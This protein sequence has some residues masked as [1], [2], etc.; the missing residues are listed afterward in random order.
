MKTKNYA[1]TML[2]VIAAIVCIAVVFALQVPNIGDYDLDGDYDFVMTEIV[3]NWDNETFYEMNTYYNISPRYAL[4]GFF[5]DVNNDN[6]LD[7][8][9]IYPNVSNKLLM[10]NSTATSRYE[11]FK[12]ITAAAGVGGSSDDPV[13]ANTADFDLDGNADLFAV[14]HLYL[15]Y[16]NGSFVDVTNESNLAEL[17]RLSRVIVW[18]FNEDNLTDIFG[19]H[20]NG[21][22][23]FLMLNMGDNDG[24]GI[25]EFYDA[26][27]LSRLSELTKSELMQSRANS[28][29]SGWIWNHTY[30]D[31]N[32][33]YLVTGVYL[34]R[35]GTDIFLDTYFSSKFTGSYTFTEIPEFRWLNISELF[36]GNTTELISGNST[37]AIFTDLDNNT[38]EDLV[39]TGSI[40]SCLADGTVNS[41]N[42]DYICHLW[43]D[44]DW[45]N[46]GEPSPT[47]NPLLFISNIR[48][49]RGQLTIFKFKN[50]GVGKAPLFGYNVPGRITEG[51]G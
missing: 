4:Y 11:I 20:E 35:N 29:A 16:G 40:T 13:G 42:L 39:I 49:T 22:E 15:G 28:I 45:N 43:L 51:G 3:Q 47:N 25:P 38:V 46:N 14:N 34:P 5:I 24:D 17:P 18:D 41:I 50:N 30:N 21:T 7:V 37:D 31:T 44:S 23:V 33:T 1:K 26:S 2:F 32:E 10:Y 8:Y 9:L 6:Y 36:T 12:D 48:G 19:M 27:T